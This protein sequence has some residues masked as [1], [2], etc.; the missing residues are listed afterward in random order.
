MSFS[1]VIFTFEVYFEGLTLLYACQRRNIIGSL[2][3]GG[4]PVLFTEYTLSSL[5]RLTWNLAVFVAILRSAMWRSHNFSCCCLWVIYLWL[6]KCII[7]VK[8]HFTC[9]L[10]TEHQSQVSAEGAITLLFFIYLSFFLSQMSNIRL[11]QTQRVC[12]WQFILFPQC[13]QNT[14]TADTWKQGL[15]RERVLNNAR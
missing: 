4:G 3:G 6:Q 9:I 12:R 14:C 8:P 15:V 7:L 11:I 10:C 1:C 5:V 13:F 2:L